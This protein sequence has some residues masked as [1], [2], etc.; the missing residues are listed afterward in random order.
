MTR[1]V[2]ARR[3]GLSYRTGVRP[4]D[5]EVPMTVTC[6]SCG[7]RR[8]HR[9][10]SLCTTCYR[11][12]A[13]SGTLHWFPALARGKYRPTQGRIEDYREVLAGEHIE[14]AASRLGVSRRTVERY[15]AQIRDTEREAG[16]A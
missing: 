10:R 7:R 6:R 9:R 12:H 3:L 16:A 14:M 13:E 2:A 5:W 1:L 8:P 11:L 4:A 15:A